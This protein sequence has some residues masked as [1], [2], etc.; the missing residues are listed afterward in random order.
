METSPDGCEA[1]LWIDYACVDQDAETR[2][3]LGDMLHEIVAG[4]DAI[5]TPIRI[6]RRRG[7]ERGVNAGC[8]GEGRALPERVRDGLCCGDAEAPHIVHGTKESSQGG[9]PLLFPPISHSKLGRM[10]P[11]GMRISREG[12]RP[13]VERVVEALLGLIVLRRRV[14]GKRGGRRAEWR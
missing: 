7:D 3:E 12:N 9:K 11:A 14:C 1:A 8:I 6:V 13:M 10:H 2:V 5:L 4:C